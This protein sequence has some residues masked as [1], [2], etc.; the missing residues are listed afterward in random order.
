MIDPVSYVVLI[1]VVLG[2]S[3]GLPLFRFSLPVRLF[4]CIA[5][6]I[7]LLFV[8]NM[9][10]LLFAFVAIGVNIVIFYVCSQLDNPRLSARVPYL[11]LLLLLIPDV[12]NGLRETPVLFLGSAF[13]IIRQ[14]MTTT[15]AGRACGSV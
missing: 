9:T 1:L 13:F 2:L 8:T 12:F 14:M 6:G 10:A 4:W 5:P 3:S 7:L 15:Q 11:I